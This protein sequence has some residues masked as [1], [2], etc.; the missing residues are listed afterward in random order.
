MHTHVLV[1]LLLFVFMVDYFAFSDLYS[2]MYSA[3][4]RAASSTLRAQ[5][6]VL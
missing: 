4:I 1:P 2:E 6:R 5:G 3:K